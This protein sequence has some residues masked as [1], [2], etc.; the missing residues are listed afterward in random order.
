M[1]L[2]VQ[3]RFLKPNYTIGKFYIDSQYYCDTLEDPVRTLKDKNKDGDFTDSGEG[4]IYG[5][6]AIPAGRYKV[7]IARWKKHNK[8]VPVIYGVPGFTGILIHA[9]ATQKDTEGCILVGRNKSIGRLSDGPYYALQITQKI[10]EA[11]NNKEEV[12][13]TIK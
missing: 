9:G 8:D 11:L 13:I 1:E 5:Q 12:W 3:R 2:G 10:Q 6:T 7:G 4:K